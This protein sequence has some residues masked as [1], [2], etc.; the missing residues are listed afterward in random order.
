[1]RGEPEAEAP[2]YSFGS[3]VTGTVSV[4][5][6]FFFSLADCLPGVRIIRAMKRASPSWTCGQSWIV[7]A[8]GVSSSG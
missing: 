6:A 7:A 4:L 3:S 5:S 8:G 2:G 1:M